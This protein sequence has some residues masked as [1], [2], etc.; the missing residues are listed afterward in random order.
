VGGLP[1]ST[2]PSSLSLF[3]FTC[4]WRRNN[5]KKTCECSYEVHVCVR[6]PAVFVSRDLTSSCLCAGRR[7]PQGSVGVTSSF[8][9]CV[10]CC[11]RNAHTHTHTCRCCYFAFISCFKSPTKQ[12]VKQTNKQM[13]KSLRCPKVE[14]L[15]HESTQT[16]INSLNSLLVACE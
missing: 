13:S 3:V 2:P 7:Q 8:L 4:L 5:N 15:T 10:F 1:S 16:V 11:C 9:Y 12:P 6:E 14:A